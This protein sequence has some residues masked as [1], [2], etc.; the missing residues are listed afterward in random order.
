MVLGAA[1]WITGHP[2]WGV[3]FSMGVMCGAICWMLQQWVPPR[4]ALVGGV[5]SLYPLASYWLASYWGGAVAA[6]GGA[7]LLGAA[8]RM[9]RRPAARWAW[10]M[11]FAVAI[12]ANSRPYEGL[13]LTA[14]VGLWML[15]RLS[16][17][18]AAKCRQVVRSAVLPFAAVLVATAGF[19]AYYNWRVTG[20]PRTIPYQVS[21]RTY[22]YR[23]MFIWQKNRPK[24]VYRHAEMEQ[25]YQALERRNRSLLSIAASKFVKPV[26]TYFSLPIAALGLVGSALLEKSADAPFAGVLGRDVRRARS[27]GV[28][29]PALFRAVRGSALRCDCANDSSCECLGEM[30]ADGGLDPRRRRARDVRREFRRAGCL[31][32]ER[33]GLRHES[34]T[35]RATTGGDARPRPRHR[36]LFLKPRTVL[37]VGV[38]PRGHRP[39]S[40]WCGPEMCPL[41]S[42]N[43]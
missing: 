10:L 11:A 5:L 6:C 4:W 20:S 18:P 16:K 35:D 30:G 42:T 24:P 33:D 22:L 2:W 23:R 26:L 1:Q 19:M 17:L 12:L 34:R 36:P 39:C 27:G 31:E 38:Q 9:L 41:P 3:C 13:V 15:I 28:G 25:A 21:F 43:S 40:R 7:L 37:G 8:A 29:E 14:S 32:V